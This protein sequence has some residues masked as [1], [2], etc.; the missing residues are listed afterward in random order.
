MIS[1]SFI[2]LNNMYGNF[3]HFPEV[4]ATF[5]IALIGFLIIF[6]LALMAF[7]IW[8]MWRVFEKGGQPGW[9]CVIPVYNFLCELCIAKKPWWWVFFLFFLFIPILGPIGYLVIHIMVCHGISTSF[10]KGAGFTVGLVLLSIVFFAIIAFDKDIKYVGT[11]TTP[12]FF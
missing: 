8:V 11:T 3:H 10:G 4:F 12:D 5:G 7:N 1:E 2:T 9:A 6:S